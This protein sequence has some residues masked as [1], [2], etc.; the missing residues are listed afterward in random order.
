MMPQS[1]LPAS[2]ME[3]PP[4]GDVEEAVTLAA[5]AFSDRLFMIVGTV[6]RETEIDNARYRHEDLLLKVNQIN[7]PETPLRDMSDAH[8]RS[9]ERFFRT[10][11][12]DY[13]WKTLSVTATA[14]ATRSEPGEGVSSST[15]F[16]L[17]VG[18]SVA[19]L[20]RSHRLQVL[21]DL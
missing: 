9:L 21:C 2:V 5:T 15:P 19:L 14:T 18:A 10:C 16:I 17:I 4:P 1:F 6:V 8:V 7:E 20:D 12:F 11:R 3:L 13:A